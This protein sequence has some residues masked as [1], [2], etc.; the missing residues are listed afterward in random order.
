MEARLITGTAAHT[1]D[2]ESVATFCARSLWS[3]SRLRG[4]GWQST[5]GAH[6]EM[7]EHILPTGG[8]AAER[9]ARLFVQRHL[10]HLITSSGGFI[11]EG[12]REESGPA[13]P[14]WTSSWSGWSGSWTSWSPSG[15]AD[16]TFSQLLLA[17]RCFWFYCSVLGQTD[18][19]VWRWTCHGSHDTADQ[20]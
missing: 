12:W 13:E 1:D 4:I 9:L 11:S 6:L 16:P 15:P 19:A 7:H 3:G 14:P 20:L 2:L 18:Q 10:M 17:G 8:S 5:S